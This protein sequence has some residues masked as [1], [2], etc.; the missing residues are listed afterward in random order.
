[1]VYTSQKKNCLMTS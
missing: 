1:V